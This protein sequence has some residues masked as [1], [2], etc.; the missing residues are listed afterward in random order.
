[1]LVYCLYISALVAAE[2]GSFAI[3]SAGK[4][5]RSKCHNK[6]MKVVF[7]GDLAC[8]QLCKTPYFTVPWHY[9]PQI[10][11][12]KQSKAHNFIS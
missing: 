8:M 3:E 2:L 11:Q 12:N 9:I 5:Q 6:S 1:M 7:H 4:L 10:S